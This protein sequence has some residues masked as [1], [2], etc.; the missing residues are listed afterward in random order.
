[1]ARNT[2]I[3]ANLSSAHASV[4]TSRGMVGAS[5]KCR[6]GVNPAPRPPAPGPV[7]F[8]SLCPAN[9]GKLGGNVVEEWN[10]GRTAE[11]GTMLLKFVLLPA[12]CMV[13]CFLQ[14]CCF[15]LFFYVH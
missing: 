7:S 10:P 12:A 9:S 5:W 15:A 11:I 4:L 8:N 6:Q 2:S 3:C 14:T 13:C 1:M